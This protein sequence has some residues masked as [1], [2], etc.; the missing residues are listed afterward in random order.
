M[1][2][3]FALFVAADEAERTAQVA[4]D[5]GI[6]AWVAGQVEPGDKRLVVEPLGV[7][8]GGEELQLR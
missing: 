2:A 4:R 8:F 3:G 5:C 7:T 6:E 1:G